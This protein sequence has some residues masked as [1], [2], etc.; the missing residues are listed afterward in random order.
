AM[1]IL[2]RLVSG[3]AGAASTGPGRLVQ[4]EEPFKSLR[5]LI[6][7]GNHAM[8]EPRKPPQPAQAS[9]E[10]IGARGASQQLFPWLIQPHLRT[11]IT[12][13]E[14]IFEIGAAAEAP[15]QPRRAGRIAWQPVELH[16]VEV[17]VF[18]D[19]PEE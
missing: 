14:P 3:G 18:R 16:D 5:S 15:G 1:E 2:E 7:I 13:F 17:D 6:G 10:V 12:R 11:D 9:G 4:C 19:V 8:I